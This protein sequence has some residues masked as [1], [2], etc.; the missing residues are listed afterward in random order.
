[1][2]GRCSQVFLAG[3]YDASRLARFEELSKLYR[4]FGRPLILDLGANVGLSVAEL[5]RDFFVICENIWSVSNV[6]CK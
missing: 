2:T 5:D 1:M 6:T 4:S 3:H